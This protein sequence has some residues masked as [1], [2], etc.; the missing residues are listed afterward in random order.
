MIDIATEKE[1][2]FY[3][4]NALCIVVMSGIL[5]AAFYFQFVGNE[6]PCPLCLLQRLAIIGVMFG[7]CLNSFYFLKARHF[8]VIIIAAFIGVLFASR[9][10]LL[11]IVPG[12]G[13]YGSDV[14]GFHM[15]V[16]SDIVFLCVILCSAVFLLLPAR[17]TE[18]MGSTT[19]R[20]KQPMY[21]RLVIYAAILLVVANILATGAECGIGP[22]QENPAAPTAAT[23]P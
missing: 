13:S 18:S 21:E 11:H 1:H 20:R 15:Y 10:V 23:T 17:I 19:P 4:L 22:C 2:F 14:F 12:T 6:E 9:Q 16:W 7:F 8:A 5:V 3:Q